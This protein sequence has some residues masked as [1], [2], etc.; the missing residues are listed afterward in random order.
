MLSTQKGI[1]SGPQ[2]ILYVRFEKN[3]I[4][5]G[6]GPPPPSYKRCIYTLKILR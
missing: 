1:F 5:F 6:G 2:A 4:F 3:N